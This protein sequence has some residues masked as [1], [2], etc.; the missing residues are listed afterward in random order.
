MQVLSTRVDLFSK[1]FG[2]YVRDNQITDLGGIKQYRISLIPV[3]RLGMEASVALHLLWTSTWLAFYLC[4]SL[5]VHWSTSNFAGPSQ[6][7]D[8]QRLFF[9]ILTNLQDS[10]P[11]VDAQT[12]RKLISEESL[13]KRWQYV[14]MVFPTDRIMKLQLETIHSQQV[15]KNVLVTCVIASV[16]VC[17]RR[18]SPYLPSPSPVPSWWYT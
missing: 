18:S 9:P 14:T 4:L 3:H 17:V 6:R 8:L 5:E 10:L 13:G 16:S 7:V 12:I 1:P 2:A 11:P 15:D